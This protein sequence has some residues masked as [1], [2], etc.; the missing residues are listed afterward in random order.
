MK[1]L[2]GKKSMSGANDP[3][4]ERYLKVQL[5]AVWKFFTGLR[6]FLY[7]TTVRPPTCG[8]LSPLWGCNL[9]LVRQAFIESSVVKLDY[10]KVSTTDLSSFDIPLWYTELQEMIWDID[11]WVWVN[12]RSSSYFEYSLKLYLALWQWA[13]AFRS[14]RYTVESGWYGFI[15]LGGSLTPYG[16]VN[17]TEMVLEHPF[18]FLT[19]LRTSEMFV[20]PFDYLLRVCEILRHCEDNA[21]V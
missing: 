9:A 15:D 21:Y 6:C 16:S 14:I 19:L 11:L 1:A 20:K 7:A 17:L 5:L 18:R 12:L 2:D 10:G 3:R 13:N 8:S 4:C